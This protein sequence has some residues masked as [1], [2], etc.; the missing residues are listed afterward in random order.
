MTG[1][2]EL[3]ERQAARLHRAFQREQ[4]HGVALATRA[5]LVALGVLLGWVLFLDGK[6][7]DP[8]PYITL[9]LLAAIGLGTWG[10]SRTRW[11][12]PWML[13][14]AV[15][16]DH[17]I[18]TAVMAAPISVGDEVVPQAL[19][20]HT[21]WFSSFFVFIAGA[22]LA[23]MPGLVVFSG[24]T[25]ALC[26]SV[27]VLWI[28]NQPDTYAISQPPLWGDRP[29]A[30]V[31]RLMTD[32]H[33]VDLS[34]WFSQMLFL[35]LVSLTL[36]AAVKR[37]R[38]LVATQ[39]ATERERA[40]LARYFS[41]EVVDKLAAK[42]SP[43]AYPKT[44]TVAV[45]FADLTG[46]TRLCENAAPEQIIDLLRGF[47]QR[48]EEAVF[49]HGGTVDKYIGDCVMATFGLLSPSA[50]DP[51]AAL[52]CARAMQVAMQD[53]NRLR[54]AQGLTPLGLGIGVHYGPV[55]AGDIG[56]DRRLEFTVVGD[57]VNVAS[58]LMHLTREL[59]A[60]IVISGEVAEAAEAVDGDAALAG[61]G[62][63]E[64]MSLRGRE[65]LVAV[66]SR[67]LPEAAA[68]TAAA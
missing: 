16:L 65:G 58:R 35:L 59:R 38:T 2:E 56:G 21:V 61:F 25:A 10:L 30:E 20:L 64:A 68:P 31:V 19:A 42:D 15:V 5:R 17:A 27:A 26:W 3:T 60:D 1:V 47:R 32:P 62:R 6:G 28:L 37:S 29:A 51:A 11:F 43:L 67:R 4:R 66:W 9:S 46:F 55:V 33:A 22:A 12:R 40:N 41:P 13:F 63:L 39:V 36:A 44:R 8:L 45:L 23:Q 53:W 18:I 14:A 52:A 49:A 50:R 57:T 7:S 54:R 34:G 24:V 48:M